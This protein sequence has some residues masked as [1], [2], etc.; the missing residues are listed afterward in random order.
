MIDSIAL[1]YEAACRAVVVVFVVNAAMILYA[2]RGAIVLGAFPSIAA[3]YS[4]YRTWLLD[5]DRSWTA[6]RAF[7][8]FGEAWRAEFPR[9]NG[10]G[11][12]LTAIWLVLLL[13]HR[14]L[15]RAEVDELGLVASGILVLVM[16]FSAVF[17]PLFWAVRANFDEPGRWLVVRTAQMVI[18]RPLCTLTVIAAELV[19]GWT[20]VQVPAAAV[21]M[22]PA[23]TIFVVCAIVFSFGRLPGM[24]AAAASAP[25]ADHINEHRTEGV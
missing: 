17:T 22:G 13:D 14:I 23:A 6:S 21:L 7:R 25:Q 3:A 20:A 18:A 12:A 5:E 24:S 8:T 9:A 4:T 10:P 2:L 1:R 19:V 11:W 15:Q 16:A